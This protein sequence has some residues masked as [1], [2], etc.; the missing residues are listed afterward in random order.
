MNDLAMTNAQLETLRRIA[1]AMG[2]PL[3]ELGHPYRERPVFDM[4][5]IHVHNSIVDFDPFKDP[6]DAFRVQVHFNL[7]VEMQVNAVVVRR[8]MGELLAMQVFDSQTSGLEEVVN[9]C[10]GA[11]VKA[12][13]VYLARE[14]L[15]KVDRRAQGV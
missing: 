8:G 15:E 6:G 1:R 14:Q 10:C 9:Q 4:D 2:L 3:D 12:A 5:N 7:T 11:V 13:A